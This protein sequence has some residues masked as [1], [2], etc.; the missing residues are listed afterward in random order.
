[1]KFVLRTKKTVNVSIPFTD[2]TSLWNHT[3][4]NSSKPL[5]IFVTGWKTN[6]E[7]EASQAQNVMADAYICRGG[8]NFV[9]NTFNFFFISFE[10]ILYRNVNEC[11]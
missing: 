7:E 2:P 5:V 4:F 1:M 10:P 6:L 11:I 3:E 9:V 8:W